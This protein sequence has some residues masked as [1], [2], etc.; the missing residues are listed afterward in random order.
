MD[1][2]HNC[3]AVA[4]RSLSPSTPSCVP[5]EEGHSSPSYVDI[6]IAFR[7]SRRTQSAFADWCVRG[8]ESL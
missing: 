4:M 2:R 6:H 5:G 1:C 7:K 3:R 8:N